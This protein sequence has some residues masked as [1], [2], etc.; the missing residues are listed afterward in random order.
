MTAFARASDQTPRGEPYKGQGA[1][2]ARIST[3]DGPFVESKEHPGGFRII[4]AEDLHA[5]LAWA[6]KTTAFVGAP[7]DVRPF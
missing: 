7:I 2:T 1:P 3:T 6:S 4:D 5:A